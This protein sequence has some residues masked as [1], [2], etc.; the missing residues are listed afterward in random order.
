[1]PV[2]NHDEAD[3]SELERLRRLESYRISRTPPEAAF[4]N[5][6]KLAAEQ[7]KVPI[8]FFCLAEKDAHWFKAKLGIE[9]EEVP[10]AISFCDYTMKS[11]S[12]MVINNATLDKR[13]ANSPMVTGAH[14]IRFYAGIPL[15]DAEGYVLGTMAVADTVPR[16]LKKQQKLL[17]KGL[18]DVILDRLELR[19][20]K[21]KMRETVESAEEARMTAVL[22][23]AKLQR[24][25]DCLPEAIVLI[26]K[27]NRLVSWNQNY[28]KMFPELA[29]LFR[30]GTSFETI[31]RR[32]LQTAPFHEGMS[33]AE[34][35]AW[36]RHRMELLDQGGSIVEQNHVDGRWIRYDQHATP[37][38]EKI[39]VRSDVTDDRNATESF[40]L[41]FENNPV[42]MWVVDKETLKFV[43]VNSAALRQYGYTR[44]QFLLMTALDI[45]P[46]REHQ[47]AIDDARNNFVSV[48]CD[49]DWIHLKVDGTEILVSSFAQPVKYK[50]ADS[51]IVAVVDV[52]ERRRQDERIQHLADHDVLTGLP[53]RRRFMELLGRSFSHQG[54]AHE[55]T[56]VILVDIDKFKE[57]NDT[58]GHYVGDNLI[59]SL[60]KRL[61]DCIGN[62]GT[63][64]RLGGDEFAIFL[65][66]IA[67]PELAQKVGVE[68]VSAFTRPLKVREHEIL[69]GISVGV[70]VGYGNSVDPS[71]LLKNADLA[72]YKSKSDG[73]GICRVYEPRMGLQ[74]IQRRELEQDLRQALAKGQFNVHYQP[75]TELATGAI[76]GFEA[77]LRWNHPDKGMIPPSVFIP[78]AESSGMIVE[79]GAWV[80]E[81]S[82]VMATT[83]QADISVAV[84]VS[85]TQFK[86]GIL[87]ATIAAVLKKS[88]LAPDRLE[89][90][91]TE[92][93][94]LENSLETLQILN[95]LKDLGVSIALDDFG[96]GYS[97][98]GYLNSFPFDKIKIDRSFIMDIGIRKKSEELVR[99]A[100]NLGHSLQMK[101]L[102]EGIET[103]EQLEFL[104]AL[105]CEQGQG[106]LFSQAI[107]A[108]EIA[109]D[110]RLQ[111]R[112]ET[113]RSLA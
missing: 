7:L 112:A 88:G 52:T 65:P 67:A 71:T 21:F 74:M 46:A 59:I 22:G 77:L 80:L 48:G 33:L 49:E 104:R 43:D 13:F 110:L 79:I 101:T 92:S 100:V 32:Y 66:T 95:G 27:H 68:L 3:F 99:A 70:S 61:K 39:C 85:S 63:V 37:D 106:Y 1:M 42:P 96:T 10:R 98:L 44:E 72:L 58:M 30:P 4:D 35:H 41:L 83:W 16:R 111:A 62:R 34:E 26:D 14:H 36:I 91:I 25:I 64:T 97:G 76:V 24:V 103:Q 31:H 78:I 15:R 105:G 113:A 54:P 69:I 45:R 9:L 90:E 51:A 6:V 23:E 108:N 60:A 86:S 18:A 109:A 89:L 11:G 28:E 29:D 19:K 53:N 56:S 12:S 82:C 47:R 5:I 55:F 17:L 8:A 38:G 94:L 81:K 2:E 73:R 93:S 102:A 50:G 84:N 57:I 87:V 107:P 75:L 20:I 40:R